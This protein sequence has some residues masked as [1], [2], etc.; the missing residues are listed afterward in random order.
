MNILKLLQEHNKNINSINDNIN[1]LLLMEKWYDPTTWFSDDT[2]STENQENQKNQKNQDDEITDPNLLSAIESGEKLLNIASSMSDTP[3]DTSTTKNK[4]IIKINLMD[5][6]KFDD[7][8]DGKTLKKG[9]SIYFNVFKIINEPNKTILILDG[10]N[11]KKIPED[12][13]L[14]ITIPYPDGLNYKNDID[15]KVEQ[16]N[17]KT[18]DKE[19]LNDIKLRILSY[20]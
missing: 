7:P 5:D 17:K 13:Q 11:N 12:L 3:I 15:A 2:K 4:N 9:G 6:I 20:N 10:K 14:K 18:N 8:Y 19:E 1:N 16:L